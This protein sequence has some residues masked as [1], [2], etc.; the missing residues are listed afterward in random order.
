MSD[1]KWL[2]KQGL[3]EV[4]RI[5][6]GFSLLVMKFETAAQHPTFNETVKSG[7]CPDKNG[8]VV[9]NSNRCPFAE[10]SHRVKSGP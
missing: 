6:S 8:I 5:S 4:E 9:C 10:L 3:E 7:E 1:T 2:L